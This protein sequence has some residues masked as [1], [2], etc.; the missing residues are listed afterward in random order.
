MQECSP[1]PSL[2]LDLNKYSYTIS[3]FLR[4]FPKNEYLISS[5]V[6]EILSFRQ[7][8]LLLYIIG[9]V[10]ANV[11]FF[12]EGNFPCAMDELGQH[13]RHPDDDLVH[14][15]HGAPGAVYLLARAYLV[16]KEDKYLHA[17]MKVGLYFLS[18]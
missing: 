15:C 2:H 12:Q 17:L 6:I 9:Y 3:G 16:W 4:G 8:I 1:K 11:Y 18:T 10:T 5:V 7:K 14:W 13:R